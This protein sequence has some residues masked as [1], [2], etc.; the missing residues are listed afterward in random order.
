MPIVTCMQ[1]VLNLEPPSWSLPNTYGMVRVE[2]GQVWFREAYAIMPP[3]ANTTPII[4]LSVS[5]LWLCAHPMAIIRHVFACPT[6]VLAVGLA[7]LMILN[8]ETC[9]RHART[10]LW[11]GGSVLGLSDSCLWSLPRR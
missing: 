7:L 6:T 9:S 10:P 3:T 11:F 5:G 8:C 2:V 4:L 1:G